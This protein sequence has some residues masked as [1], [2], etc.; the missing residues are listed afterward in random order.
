MPQPISPTELPQSRP[1]DSKKRN[2][3]LLKVRNYRQEEDWAK[4]GLP[5]TRKEI[6]NW[7]IKTSQYY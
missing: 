3:S 7:H 1:F 5:I 2:D 4:M 6:S